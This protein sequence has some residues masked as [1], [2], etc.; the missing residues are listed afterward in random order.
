[1]YEEYGHLLSKG[2]KQVLLDSVYLATK[3]DTY[4][5]HNDRILSPKPLTRAFRSWWCR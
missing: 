4:R 1:M 5:K 2:T 3:G